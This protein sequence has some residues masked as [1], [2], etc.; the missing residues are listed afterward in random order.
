MGLENLFFGLL[1]SGCLRQVLLYMYG[2]LIG[3]CA[4]IRG[5]IVS[6]KTLRASIVI[7]DLS[8]AEKNRN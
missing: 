1:L 8:F 4:F 3:A 6:D 5:N 7:L 2:M